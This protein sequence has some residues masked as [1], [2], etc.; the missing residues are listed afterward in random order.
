[1]LNE[2][3]LITQGGEVILS[4]PHRDMT[5]TFGFGGVRT[6]A[7]EHEHDEEEDEDH[8]HEEEEHHIEADEAGFNNWVTTADLKWALPGDGSATASASIGV[9]ENGFGE[10]TFVYGFG[11]QKIWGA[12]DDGDGPEFSEGSLLL[13]TELIGR[14]FDAA[15]E[16]GEVL[17]FDDQGVSTSL[18]YGLAEAT[19]VSFRHEWVS[20]IEDLEL[21]D[22]HRY[23]PA[24]TTR[25]GRHCNIQA[26]LQYDY[27]QNASLPSEHVGWLQI[28]WQWGGGG[29]GH[30]HC[31]RISTTNLRC[32]HDGG[33]HS[34]RSISRPGEFRRSDRRKKRF[35]IPHPGV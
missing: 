30:D 35:P 11:L 7:H 25:L 10:T 27:N 13:R 14:E 20:G 6:H 17:D 1:M 28:M 24:F 22:Y 29:H 33:D 9:G 4:H 8:D 19:T 23:S 16:D 18:I 31:S 34:P 21:A 2:G 5:L 3:E 12:H 32:L 15:D 26:R